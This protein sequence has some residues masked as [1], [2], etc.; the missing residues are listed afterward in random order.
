MNPGTLS[1]SS[2]TTSAMS[3]KKMAFRASPNSVTP[4]RVIFP[5]LYDDTNSRVCPK[6]TSNDDEKSPV[7]CHR[8]VPSLDSSDHAAAVH[9][10]I[11]FSPMMSKNILR[12]R[13]NVLSQ[14]P[15]QVVDMPVFPDLQIP[16]HSSPQVPP[17]PSSHDELPQPSAT[18]QKSKSDHQASNSICP[19]RPPKLGILHRG[20][21]SP[22]KSILRNK[23]C[24]LSKNDAGSE[25][26]IP[27]LASSTMSDHD[28]CSSLLE[29]LPSLLVYPRRQVSIEHSPHQCTPRT[30]A[31]DPRVWIT[32]FE[33]S[34]EEITSTW[35]KTSDMNRFKREAINR[36]CQASKSEFLPTGTGRVVRRPIH[37]HKALFTH[38]ALTTL[39]GDD[40]EDEA[41]IKRLAEV[42]LK[43]VLIVDPH[44]ICLKLF[45]KAIKSMLPHATI[46]TARTSNEAIVRMMDCKHFDMVIVEERLGLF[47]GQ[48]DPNRLN[49]EVS[50][51]AL[52]QLLASQQGCLSESERSGTLWIAVSAHYKTHEE[53]MKA[54]GADFQWPKPPPC[55]NQEM[56][57]T[58]LKT[59]L[60]KRCKEE[61]ALAYFG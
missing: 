42:E 18:L 17:P 48:E 16:Q 53:R 12:S 58:L 29:A 14:T 37:Q 9:S 54:S 47:H 33:R 25:E 52:I 1:P 55:F 57:D 59:L 3:P 61:V 10:L 49:H 46:M 6:T 36:I 15:N 45:G 26:S 20:H 43:S 40:S 34:K 35:Y 60:M 30:V 22:L 23:I 39:D 44:D 2:Q 13:C 32:V 11:L 31:F 19:Y 7:S 21:T 50:G 8:R 56:R 28:N 24:P 41:A 5:N 38:P 4:R 27:S 51:S